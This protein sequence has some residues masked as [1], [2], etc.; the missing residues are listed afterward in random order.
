MAFMF[1]FVNMVYHTGW[2]V[3]IEE[4]LHPW[5]KPDLIMVCGFYNMLLYS[6]CWNF[7]DDFYIYIHQ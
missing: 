1:Q 4:S 2:F 6:S 3:Y 7:V 5:S